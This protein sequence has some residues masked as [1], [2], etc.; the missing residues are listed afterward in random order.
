MTTRTAHGG[1]RSSAISAVNN[2]KTRDFDHVVRHVCADLTGT[3]CLDSAMAATTAVFVPD[4]IILSDLAAARDAEFLAANRCG[5]CSSW[6]WC[7][8]V[9]LW[10][11]LRGCLFLHALCCC[12][13][14][15][16]GLA[17]RDGRGSD[18]APCSLAQRARVRVR[19]R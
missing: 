2:R 16:Q 17:H 9:H 14:G 10:V 13:T 19:E 4:F 11:C 7:M 6:V 18:V 12:D 3:P 8:R 5:S 15:R 1:A